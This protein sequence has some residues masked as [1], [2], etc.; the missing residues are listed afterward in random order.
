[1]QQQGFMV[2]A[3][4]EEKVVA[5]A[6][7]FRGTA[8]LHYHLSA[9]DIS[10]RIPGVMNAVLYTAAMHEKGSLMTKLH[11]GGGRT[12][13]PDDSLLKF[14]RTMGTDSHTFFF[15]K[16]IHNSEIYSKLRE[17]WCRDYPHL[18]GK[19]GSQLLCYHNTK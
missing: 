1:M 8:Y 4:Y 13:A 5:A 15:G 6:I 11:L 16:R 10:N 18:V 9:T 3:K 19:Y 7:F 14:K 17:D 12:S 2:V